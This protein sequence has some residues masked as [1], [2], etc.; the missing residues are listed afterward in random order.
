MIVHHPLRLGDAQV[1]NPIMVAI[2]AGSIFG[3]YPYV[4]S[5][6]EQVSP[7]PWLTLPFRG[8]ETIRLAHLEQDA[9]IL[10]RSQVARQQT[11][12]HVAQGP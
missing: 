9:K 3:S 2:D 11:I 5:F 4:S 1:R 6:N 12:P 7:T 8:N 10:H